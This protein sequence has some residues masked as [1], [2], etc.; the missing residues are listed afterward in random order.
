MAIPNKNEHISADNELLKDFEEQEQ[1]PASNEL[2]SSDEE[3]LIDDEPIE[4][5]KYE[6]LLPKT[7]D[8]TR[9]VDAIVLSNKTGKPVKF[10]FVVKVGGLGLEKIR[11]GQKRL[12]ELNRNGTTNMDL[13]GHILSIWTSIVLKQPIFFKED[14]KRYVTGKQTHL[15]GSLIAEILI[16]VWQ[17]H[18]DIIQYEDGEQQVKN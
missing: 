4:E 6:D 9:T 15:E 2:I 8:N 14:L 11:Q 17:A 5:G 10:S 1:D 3:D 13:I 18:K 7:K 12:Y 16:Q